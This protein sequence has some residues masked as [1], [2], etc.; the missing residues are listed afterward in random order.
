M[1]GLLWSLLSWVMP[2]L[3]GGGSWWLSNKVKGRNGQ[4]ALRLASMGFYSLLLPQIIW[5]LGW[6]IPFGLI[7]YIL[8]WFIPVIFF[9]AAGNSLLR[10]V[11]AQQRGEYTEK[12][13]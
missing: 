3:L 13:I 12:A 8:S 1:F 7:F 5:L 10:E 11:R 6:L 4:K 2:I 9:L